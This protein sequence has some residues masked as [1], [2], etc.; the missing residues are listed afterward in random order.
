M[1]SAR[2]KVA[3]K[4]ITG[5][6]SVRYRSQN[7]GLLFMLCEL[8]VAELDALRSALLASPTLSPP[9]LSLLEKLE[10]R[11]EHFPLDPRSSSVWQIQE[12]AYLQGYRAGLLVAKGVTPS[13]VCFRYM[14]SFH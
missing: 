3:D 1:K 14:T 8:E 12:S 6:L 13:E 9:L 7:L 10:G 2:M 5:S 11:H 4:D